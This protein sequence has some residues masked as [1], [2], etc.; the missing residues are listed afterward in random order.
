L[1]RLLWCVEWLCFEN[2]DCAS[3]VPK[4]VRHAS[5]RNGRTTGGSGVRRSLLHICLIDADLA[6]GAGKNITENITEPERANTANPLNIGS[7]NR[8]NLSTDGLRPW[9]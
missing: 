6:R 8:A 9:R 4:R 1:L 3:D 5:A 7:P 2:V